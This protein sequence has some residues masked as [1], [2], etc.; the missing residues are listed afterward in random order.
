M[1]TN[2]SRIAIVTGASSG[3]GEAIA[4][5]LVQTGCGVVIN[6]RRGDRLE[7]IA[8]ELGSAC[9][10]AQ[11]DASNPEII[12]SLF[13]TARRHFSRE[14]DIVIVNAGRGL[15]GSVTTADLSQFEEVVRINLVG[16]AALLQ[17]A[18]LK[19][20]DDLKGR[21]FPQFA[22]DIIVIGSTV[23][24]NIS[25]FSV[26]Y[27]STKFAIHSI[28][29]GLRREVGPKGIRVSL[30][31]PGIVLSEFQ[32]VAGYSGDMVNSFEQKFGPLLIGEDIA[33][34]VEFIVSQPAH[35]HISDMVVRPTR[36]EYP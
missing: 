22:R 5:R 15:G 17:Q 21:P 10:V 32:N 36:Q 31:E 29:E 27:G 33:S 8:A 23:G 35:I 25:P 9:C 30:V 3:I 7:A 20:V 26:V 18:A 12:S 2:Y 28:T 19:M 1:E 14:A 24:R 4:K 13:S 11:G 16:A 34:L 6:A